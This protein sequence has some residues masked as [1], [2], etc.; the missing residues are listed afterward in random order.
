MKLG[1]DGYVVTSERSNQPENSTLFR[2]SQTNLPTSTIELNSYLLSHHSPITTRARNQ[3][4]LGAY[5]A[6]IFNEQGNQR[7]FYDQYEYIAERTLIPLPPP[8]NQDLTY[9]YI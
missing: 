2:R 1:E 4:A 9:D 6:L 5:Q 3:S 7:N 8:P